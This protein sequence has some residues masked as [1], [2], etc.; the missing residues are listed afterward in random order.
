[1]KSKI[2]RIL[3][4]AILAAGMLLLGGSDAN[5][6]PYY[7]TLMARA[8][9][10][11]ST[12]GMRRGLTGGTLMKVSRLSPA[13]R[14]SPVLRTASNPVIQATGASN[15]AA[16]QQGRAL[17]AGMVGNQP[18]AATRQLGAAHT[19]GASTGLSLAGLIPTP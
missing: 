18:L 6:N 17:R 13:V 14:L 19:G 1:M 15:T 8:N 9:A 4:S 11:A 10:M 5:A 12:A 2:K 16:L 7:A 3:G